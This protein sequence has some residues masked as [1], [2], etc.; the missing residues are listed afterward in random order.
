MRCLFF[1]PCLLAVLVPAAAGAANE[2]PSAVS[3]RGSFII[4]RSGSSSTEVFYGDGPV[5]RTV[6]KSGGR[7]L[8]ETTQHEGLIQL[9]RID[10][11]RRIVYKPKS[12]LAKLFPLRPKQKMDVVFD[13]AEAGASPSISSIR[14]A[15][16]GLDTLSIGRCKYDVVKIERAETHR[17]QKW[18]PIVEYYAP[19]LK[20]VI[21]KEYK[22]H[23]GRVTLI[24]FDAISQGSSQAGK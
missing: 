24:K 14:L 2:C 23:D 21:G 16:V 1:A 20:L 11:G 17:G 3:G 13:T 6:M 4:E 22:E 9:D 15:V 7:V 12:D 5:V 18:P 10:R 19:E 8:L